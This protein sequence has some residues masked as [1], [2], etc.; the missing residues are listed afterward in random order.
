MALQNFGQLKTSIASLLNRSDLEAVI[1]DFTA[2]LEA[3]VNREVRFRNRRQEGTAALAFTNG[4]ATL[5]VDFMEART[6]VFLSTPRVRM[7]YL[8]PSS[9]EN[10]YR[11]DTP[12]TPANYTIVGDTL[13]SGPH[14]NSSAGATI[15][16]YKRLTPLTA[17]ADTNWL[18]Q[19]HPDVYLYGAALH[20]APYLGEDNR[21]QTWVGFMETASLQV[22]GDD[23]RARWNGAPIRPTLSVTIV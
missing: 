10:L 13:K 3:Q 19:Y 17:D 4:I 22:A 16:Y 12:G 1:P 14:P 5:P 2:M 9:F 7:E 8:S 18:L 6:V 21:L 20:S 23:S 15:T 11:V